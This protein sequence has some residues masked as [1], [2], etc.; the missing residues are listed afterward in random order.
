MTFFSFGRKQANGNFFLVN[1]QMEKLS[2]EYH[3][4]WKPS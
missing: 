4:E 3:E 1:M 2:Q